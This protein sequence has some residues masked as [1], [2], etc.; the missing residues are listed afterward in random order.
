MVLYIVGNDI[1]H[2]GKYFD[3]KLLKLFLL[4]FNL[5]CILSSLCENLRKEKGIKRR[6]LPELPKR[7]MIGNI[8]H[9]ICKH[10]MYS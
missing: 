1:V 4:S 8:L 5:I 7:T 6:D 3:I 2:F 9:N 10:K